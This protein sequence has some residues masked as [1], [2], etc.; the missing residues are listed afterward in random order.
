M[1]RVSDPVC[2]GVQHAVNAAVGSRGRR[3]SLTG[4]RFDSCPSLHNM[5]RAS[6]WEWCVR[7]KVFLDGAKVVCGSSCVNE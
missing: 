5:Q 1:S 2:S 4:G 3:R 6:E 7:F